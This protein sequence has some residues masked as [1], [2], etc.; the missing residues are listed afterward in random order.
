MGVW[1]IPHKRKRPL[2]K[3]SNWG[4][5]WLRNYA[6]KARQRLFRNWRRPDVGIARGAGRVDSPV[7]T[8]CRISRTVTPTRR[9][10]VVRTAPLLEIVPIAAVLAELS[11]AVPAADWVVWVSPS[12]IDVSWPAMAPFLLSHTRFAT[13]GAA[14]A[15]RLA[16][17]TSR[18]VSFPTAADDSEALL[19]FQNG[20]LW[21]EKRCC[22]SMVNKG[23][24]I[25]H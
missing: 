5:N 23:D 21:M 12:A 17:Y 9:C 10:G 4:N 7:T 11:T 25:W 22:S 1:F 24:R 8:E 15:K 20:K 13:V 14:S 6:N 18:P 19:A 2:P 3:P 16:R